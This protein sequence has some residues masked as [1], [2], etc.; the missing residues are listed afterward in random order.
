[1][2]VHHHVQSLAYPVYLMGPVN[3]SHGDL[4]TEVSIVAR[5]LGRMGQYAIAG[6]CLRM[7]EGDAG[8]MTKGV[9]APRM[10]T[11]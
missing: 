1:M 7:L 2:M 10:T 5:I 8:L 6:V 9:A 4:S 11:P 3:P